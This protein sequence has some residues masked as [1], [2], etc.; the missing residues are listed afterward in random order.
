MQ[1]SQ[2]EVI[3]LQYLA[4]QETTSSLLASQLNAALSNT[5]LSPSTLVAPS[6]SSLLLS[7]IASNRIT[8][9]SAQRGSIMFGTYNCLGL[10]A[11]NI[12]LSSNPLSP[13]V[14]F[15]S[16]Y[17]PQNQIIGYQLPSPPPPSQDSPKSDGLSSSSIGAIV[18]SVLGFAALVGLSAVGVVWLLNKRRR[19]EIEYEKASTSRASI[20]AYVNVVVDGREAPSSGPHSHLT[21]PASTNSPPAYDNPGP[22]NAFIITRAGKH[23]VH[24]TEPTNI[25]ESPKDQKATLPRCRSQPCLAKSEWVESEG[26]NAVPIFSGGLALSPIMEEPQ[27]PAG[28]KK[29][30]IERSKSMSSSAFA[31]KMP[32][33]PV[34]DGLAGGSISTDPQDAMERAVKRHLLALHDKSNDSGESGQ[35]PHSTQPDL[36][37]QVQLEN[38][39]GQGSFGI[40]YKGK[41]RSM[42]V[43]VKALLFHDA[44]TAKRVRQR[45]LTEAAINQ[46]LSNDNIVNT[47]AYDLRTLTPD[48]NL[49][50]SHLVAGTHWKLYIVQEFCDG[51]PL[52]DFID[53]G[54]L[55][56]QGRVNWE[57]IL[58][59]TIDI[60]KGLVYIHDNQIIHGDLSSGNIL[61]K[62]EADSSS[63]FIAKVSDFGLSRFL[64]VGQSHISNARQGTPFYIAP[65]I[66]SRGLISKAADIFSIGVLLREMAVGSI[67]PWRQ[68]RDETSPRVIRDPSRPPST[69]EHE[70][71]PLTFDYRIPSEVICPRGYREVTHA[72]LA[73]DPKKRPK[74]DDLLKLMSMINSALLSA[75]RSQPVQEPILLSKGSGKVESAPTLA[76]GAAP[77][78][79]AKNVG[80]L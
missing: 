51:G 32:P 18:G 73:P 55:L 80:Y 65:E 79:R 29:R 22:D 48:N 70:I 11:T 10:I 49:P 75:P 9:S 71:H 34:K 36:M 6:A 20:P 7:L 45:A 35:V 39:L 76:T 30:V 57:W 46:L 23:M 16:S 25:V 54:R 3:A 64:S 63:S 74:A 31:L 8:L 61:L 41:W 28:K 78:K 38:V 42:T 13:S 60:L 2:A 50:D 59:L 26:S 68:V 33:L 44:S 21:F 53:R 37:M 1:V 15:N 43:A 77:P 56:S 14:S 58:Q 67:P 17:V 12:S 40:V 69:H 27:V 66:I 4:Q 19:A 47:Y 5:S 24:P 72:C 62:S 52:S